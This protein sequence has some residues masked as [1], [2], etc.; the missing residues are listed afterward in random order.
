MIRVDRRLGLTTLALVVA[1]APGMTACVRGGVIAL[2]SGST[3]PSGEG[4][5]PISALAPSTFGPLS[6]DQGLPAWFIAGTAQSSQ[7]GYASLALTAAQLA[8]IASQGFTMTMTDR[9]IQSMAPAYD[10]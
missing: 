6:N 4:F 3:N 2:H 10:S 1:L 7:Y 8:T 9:V 5:T